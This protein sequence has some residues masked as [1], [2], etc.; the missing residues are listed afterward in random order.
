MYEKKLKVLHVHDVAFVGSTLIAGFNEI[1]VDAEFYEFASHKNNNLP[2][3]LKFISKALLMIYEIFRFGWYVRKNKFDIVH[4]HFGSFAYLPILNNINFLLHIH[5]SELRKFI[6][7]PILG[8]I[9]RRGIKKAIAVF[10]TTPDLEELIYEIRPDAIFFPNAVNIDLFKPSPFTNVDHSKS[11]LVI[12]KMDQ[13]KGIKDILT[14]IELMWDDDPSIYVYMFGFGNALEIA[15]SFIDKNQTNSQL[16][17]YEPLDHDQMPSLIN[18]STVVFGQLG[19]G[20]LTCSELEAM[21]CGKPVVCN[22]NFP[23]KYP[24]PPPICCAKTPDEAKKQIVK[25]I[26][27]PDIAERIGREARKW[28]VEN[29]GKRT[30]ARKLLNHYKIALANTKQFNSE[31]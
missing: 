19:T 15:K 7:Y 4:L 22:F 31:D 21:A 9:I 6:N 26:N 5:G 3:L 30:V 25:L 14:S 13:F 2:K 16:I 10:Y 27:E 20:I 28:I 24:T 12:S 8:N 23:Q 1:G 18:E 29:Y 17:I 11:V